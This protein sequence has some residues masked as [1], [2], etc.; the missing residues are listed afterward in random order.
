MKA[1]MMARPYAAIVKRRPAGAVYIAATASLP[2]E[3]N[4]IAE[5][6]GHKTFPEP[7]PIACHTFK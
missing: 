4:F 3:F 7:E 5:P 2:H 6:R 1:V